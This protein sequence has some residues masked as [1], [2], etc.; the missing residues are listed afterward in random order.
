MRDED[1]R[2]KTP[3]GQPSDAELQLFGIAEL[4]AR[5]ATLKGQ[6]EQ[7]ERLIAAKRDQRGLADR[8]FSK[9]GE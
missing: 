4:E 7:C 1:D 9:G 3:A 5:I 2:P 6:I 8:L